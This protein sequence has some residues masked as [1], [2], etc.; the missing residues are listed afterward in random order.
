M[1][2]I[3]QSA[4]DDVIGGTPRWVLAEPGKPVW[5][6]DVACCDDVTVRNPS[7]QCPLKCSVSYCVCDVWHGWAMTLNFRVKP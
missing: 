4:L 6:W 1:L 2:Q 5:V 3:K 7:I